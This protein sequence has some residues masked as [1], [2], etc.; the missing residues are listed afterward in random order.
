MKRAAHKRIWRLDRAH[1]RSEGRTIGVEALQMSAAQPLENGRASGTAGGRLGL[2][3]RAEPQRRKREYERADQCHKYTA[4][5]PAR[6]KSVRPD[7]GMGFQPMKTRAGSPCYDF[8]HGL[9]RIPEY[10]D[11]DHNLL[12]FN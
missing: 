4:G 10:T 2:S 11:R 1:A 9:L 8:R 3:R 7:R 5:L 6:G 12:H